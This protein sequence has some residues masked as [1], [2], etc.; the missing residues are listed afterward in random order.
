MK[1]T[2][3]EIRQKDF[4]KKLRGYDK[5]EV[6]AFL[7]SLS[8]EWERVLD[9]NKECRIKLDQAEKEV[10]KLREV[11]N[12]LF[13][14][15]K[16]AEDTG[17]N[18]VDQANKAAELHLRETQMNAEAL[19]SE[20]KSKAKS[21]IEK[22]EMQAK[23][24]ITEMQEATKDLEQNYRSIENHRDNLITE[25]RN[26]SADI[27]ERLERTTK[28][29]ASFKVQDHLAKVR[30]LVRESDKR[31]EQESIRKPKAEKLEVPTEKEPTKPQVIAENHKVKPANQIKAE[32]VQATATV[33]KES[34]ED[35]KPDGAGS[36][37]DDLED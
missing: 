5:D 22:A 16:T 17:A 20:S 3:L 35:S 6:N 7:V 10:A 37:F 2:P 28:Q 31:I 27:M 26:L 15:L 24:L 23:E 21:I 11:E 8:N 14:T 25:M 13:K 12:S 33:I 4:E 29:S 18:L 1:I 32:Q 9:E 19:M 36:F 30:E 34:S